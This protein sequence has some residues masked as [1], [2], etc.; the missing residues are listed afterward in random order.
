[1]LSFWSIA[2]TPMALMCRDDFTPS[3]I[4]SNTASKEDRVPCPTAVCSHAIGP[5][6]MPSWPGDDVV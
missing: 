6:R 3:K 5:R 2:L 4:A 1:M